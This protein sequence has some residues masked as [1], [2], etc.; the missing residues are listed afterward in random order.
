MSAPGSILS[1]GRLRFCQTTVGKKAVMAITGVILFGFVVGHLLGNLQI[2]LHRSTS[3]IRRVLRS[4]R[5]VWGARIICLVSVGLHIWSS[6]PAL[7]AATRSPARGVREEGRP[8]HLRLAHHDVERPDLAG[9]SSSSTCLHLT[10]G[11]VHAGGRSRA[12][13]LQQ[14]DYA[15]FRCGRSRRSTSSP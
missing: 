2:F 6:L 8:T 15:A 1:A 5:A 12:Q 4:L 7:A 10:L 14:R 3:I 11:A 13:R 9:L